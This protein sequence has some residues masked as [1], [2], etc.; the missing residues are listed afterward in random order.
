MKTGGMALV[1][2]V[3]TNFT[4]EEVYPHP[5]FDLGGHSSDNIPLKVLRMDYLRAL[6]SERRTQIRLYAT[7][8]P[9]VACEVLGGGFNTMTMVRDPV[10]RT[11]SLLRQFQ[12]YETATSTDRRAE[13]PELEQI[14]E[15]ADVFEP[16]VHNHQTKLFSI[17]LADNPMGYMQTI[18]VDEARLA[19][20]RQNLASVDV[21]GLTEHHAD[22]VEE[23][24]LRFGWRL[25]RGVR[26]NA[27]PDDPPSISESFRRR[28]AADNAID[29]EF[30]D[31]A[32]QL[33]ASRRN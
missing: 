33:V 21:V 24:V 12:R 17:T 10:E 32:T 2:N 14:Y 26:A 31:Y 20:A 27:A 4:V 11:I 7:H 5:V 1:T 16:L 6:P 23:L 19:L 22:F 25:K 29:I 18:D 3:S 13:M 15:R 8:F 9:F 28:I 30:Y